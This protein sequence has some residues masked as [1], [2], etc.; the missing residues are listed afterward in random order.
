[1]V[2]VVVLGCEILMMFGYDGGVFVFVELW[3]GVM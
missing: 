3:F 1:M 2:V